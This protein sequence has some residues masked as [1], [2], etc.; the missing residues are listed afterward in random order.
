[1]YLVLLTKPTSFT[2]SRGRSPRAKFLEHRNC[3]FEPLFMMLLDNS[4]FIVCHA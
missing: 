3:H 4:S 1:M 2:S